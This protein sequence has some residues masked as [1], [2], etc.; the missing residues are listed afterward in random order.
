M[1]AALAVALV[2]FACGCCCIQPTAETASTTL[3]EPTTLAEE[4]TTTSEAEPTSSTTTTLLEA[5]M[6]AYVE[7]MWWQ[8][9]ESR[10][11]GGRDT[12]NSSLRVEYV[13]S[14]MPGVLEFEKKYEGLLPAR[15]D[16]TATVVSLAKEQYTLADGK[17]VLDERVTHPKAATGGSTSYNYLPGRVELVF[18]LYVGREWSGSSEVSVRHLNHLTHKLRVDYRAAV[19]GVSRESTAAGDFTCFRVDYAED[20]YYGSRLLRTTAESR[21]YCPGLGY[22]GGWLGDVTLPSG[23]FYEE[24]R[25]TQTQTL[26]KLQKEHVESTLLMHGVGSE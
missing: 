11:E 9:R 12:Y 22:Y 7:G 4:L 24:Y 8:Y 21:F 26:L 15:G 6:P 3:A 19:V 2:V 14:P 25:I 10:T 1:K 16:S 20:E 18:P 23:L 17:L 13:G 5:G